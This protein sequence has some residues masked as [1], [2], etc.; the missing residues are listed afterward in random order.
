[1]KNVFAVF[2]QV[3]ILGPIKKLLNAT[4]KNKKTQTNFGTSPLQGNHLVDQTDL[5]FV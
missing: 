3:P 1:M 5:G 2:L 4:Y